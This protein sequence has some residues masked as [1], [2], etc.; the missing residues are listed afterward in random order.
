[1][2][3]SVHP[4][5]R[6]TFTS[7]TLV[8]F[9]ALILTACGGS[10]GGGDDNTDSEG[11]VGSEP[12][13]PT[14]ELF[15]LDICD[16]EPYASIQPFNREPQLEQSAGCVVNYMQSSSDP[17]TTEYFGTDT[18]ERRYVV[19]APLELPTSAVPVVFMFHGGTGAVNAESSASL[20][21]HTSFERLADE[22]GFIV[23]YG[24]GL[25]LQLSGDQIALDGGWFHSCFAPHGGEGID[26]QHVREILDQL[27]S[28]IN[29]DRTRVYATGLSAGGGMALQLAME[30]P[31]LVA[32]VAPVAPLPWETEG[33]WLF[34]CNPATEG[35][36][37]VPIAMYAATADRFIPYL[38]GPGIRFPDNNYPGMEETRD[39]WLNIMGIT[40]DPVIETRANTVA[41]DSF[42]EHSGITDSFVEV[43]KYPEGSMGSEYWF[44]HA[45]G[46]GHW[47][48]HP[49]QSIDFFWEDFGKTNQDID[50]AEEAWKF[51]ERH[52]KE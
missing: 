24:N 4:S 14:S 15:R 7:F 3:F 41:D 38:Q 40:G 11:S 6:H 34:E 46:A 49:T 10:D 31:D 48:P 35:L 8:A 19:Y 32:A 5:T 27:E 52:S 37:S 28:E 50:F 44:F 47:W 12:N 1:M 9:L 21:T 2:I 18:F 20:Y 45:E 16:A 25:T 30:A 33:S 43:Y 36:G 39:H 17:Q 29:I 13:N 26:V 22:H 42:E 51:F 23:V